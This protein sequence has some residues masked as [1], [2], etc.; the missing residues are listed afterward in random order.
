MVVT[1]QAEQ[2]ARSIKTESN[3]M[4]DENYYYKFELRHKE[5]LMSQQKN[6]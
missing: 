6:V 5:H 3:H 2:I 4:K 1:V